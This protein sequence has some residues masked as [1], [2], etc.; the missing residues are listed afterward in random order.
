M[1][2][3]YSVDIEYSGCFNIKSHF[4]KKNKNK[5]RHTPRKHFYPKMNDNT[6]QYI[7]VNTQRC[8]LL[9]VKQRYI[10]REMIKEVTQTLSDS[11]CKLQTNQG[12][13][14]KLH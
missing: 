2:T 9:V 11:L 4:Q 1:E 12:G 5:H 14:L 3:T 8:N 13:V 6:S 7:D 10:G